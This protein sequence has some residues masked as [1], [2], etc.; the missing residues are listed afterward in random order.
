VTAYCAITKPGVGGELRCDLPPDHPGDK[1]AM[2][3]MNPFIPGKVAFI[4]EWTLDGAEPQREV[5][6]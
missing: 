6:K 4:H 5:S 2:G 1:H 3:L